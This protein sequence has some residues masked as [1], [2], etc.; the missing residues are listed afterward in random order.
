[1]GVSPAD[2]DPQSRSDIGLG[3]EQK[4]QTSQKYIDPSVGVSSFPLPGI[5]LPLLV[6]RQSLDGSRSGH[7]ARGLMRG[8][9]KRYPLGDG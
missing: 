4:R 8:L 3:P 9:K 6:R 2:P 1:M 7:E 5:V